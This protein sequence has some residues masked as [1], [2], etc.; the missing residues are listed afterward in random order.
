ME[1]VNL[2]QVFAACT[3]SFPDKIYAV[4]D[5]KEITYKQTNER[6]NKL[7]NGLR[8]M[9]Y[10]K[11]THASMWGFASQQF[12][13]LWWAIAKGGIVFSCINPRYITHGAV[14]QC[15]HS[16]C[17]ILFFDEEYLDMVK[18]AKSQ[19]EKVTLYVIIG[20]KRV[21]G[22][23]NYE[24]I[25]AKGSPEEPPEEAF[26][27]D[28]E[29]QLIMYTG[30]TTGTPKGTVKTHGGTLWFPIQMT[31]NVH[32]DRY[33]TCANIFPLHHFGG[34]VFVHS[35]GYNGGTIVLQRRFD[36]VELL[37]LA[38]RYK[39]DT[40][41]GVNTAL[42]ALTRVPDEIKSK[43]DF[44]NVTTVFA[45]GEFLKGMTVSALRAMFPNVKKILHA[46]MYS[47]C[48]GATYIDLMKEPGKAES[49]V[50]KLSFGT[51]GYIGDEEGNELP[52]GQSGLFW[53]RCGANTLEFW[54]NPGLTQKNIKNGYST[55]EDIMSQ[56]DEN[57]F[58]FLD[59]SSDFVCTGGENVS[60]LK[61]ESIIYENSKVA[62]AAVVGLPDE[63]WGQVVTAFITLKAGQ[64]CTE[65]EIIAHCRKKLAGFETPKSVRFIEEI[66]K[67]A[68]G[69][70]NKK[71]LRQLCQ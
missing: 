10:K 49:C 40:I 28:E 60:T 1:N 29:L 37:K 56:D 39:A 44:S 15:N 57:Y 48:P 50:G 66:P 14:E 6:V 3:R 22:M 23:Y 68:V 53:G 27:K 18:S 5:D 63:K 45:S 52:K 47:E 59:R 36:P 17:Q 69:K 12:V 20:E 8:S 54:K 13:E 65:E 7:V 62:E 34:E 33:S 26:T 21:D 24:D 61:V 64:E 31:Q 19:L 42:F 51:D 55:A 46:Y 30:G 70:I 9:G 58:Y 35:I 32:F 67:T 71:Q 25:V 43:L 38:H 41:S 4:I 11:G 16:D 2:G